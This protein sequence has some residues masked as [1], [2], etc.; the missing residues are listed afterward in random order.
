MAGLTAFRAGRW[1]LGVGSGPGVG[2]DL[3]LEEPGGQ[4]PPEFAGTLLPLVEGEELILEFGADH[5]IEGGRG[6]V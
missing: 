3:L 1:L 4:V 5:E 6:V 2:V